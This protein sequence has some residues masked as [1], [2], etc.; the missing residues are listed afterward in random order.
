MK[1]EC[2]TISEGNEVGDERMQSKLPVD[3]L[4]ACCITGS[5]GWVA[6]QGATADLWSAGD[7]RASASGGYDFKYID[8]A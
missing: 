3:K 5:I 6:L 2:G 1:H 7:V 4:S 8:P